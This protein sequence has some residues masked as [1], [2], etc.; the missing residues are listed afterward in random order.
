MYSTAP[1]QM[2]HLR[3]VD[4]LHMGEAKRRLLPNILITGTPGTGKTTTAELVAEQ[5]GLRHINVGELVKS[6]HLHCGWDA[7]H[8]CFVLDEDKV[9]PCCL[10][11][12]QRSH[13]LTVYV[14]GYAWGRMWLG[15]AL[16]V[17][18]RPCLVRPAPAG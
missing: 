17:Q 5:T 11:L 10:A 14:A 8:D 2:S 12:P 7:E 15:A 1:L 9:P 3:V 16:A 4:L 13:C 18:P 6:E